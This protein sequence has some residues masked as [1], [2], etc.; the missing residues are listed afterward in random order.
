MLM[1]NM[2]PFIL[3]YFMK[4]PGLIC[5]LIQ[6]PSDTPAIGRHLPS[7]VLGTIGEYQ[8]VQD[9]VILLIAVIW[10]II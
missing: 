9:Y 3:V 2:R 10:L 7:D 1:W 4:I 8:N 6:T 5:G